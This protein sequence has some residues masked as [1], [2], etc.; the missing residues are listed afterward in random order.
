MTSKKLKGTCFLTEFEPRT[1]KDALNNES[2]IEE[3]IK[4][5]KKL[6]GIKLGLLFLEPKIKMQL[7][8][9]RYSKIS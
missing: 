6:K 8:Q 3:I 2:W 7:A 4:R 9:S 1:I 5:L